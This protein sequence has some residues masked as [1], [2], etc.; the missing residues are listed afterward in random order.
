MTKIVLA[1]D[2]QV[3]RR[4]IK[5]LLSTE[6]DFDIIGEAGNG[7]ETVDLVTKLQPDILV[8]DLGMPGINGLEVT[9]QL[10][11]SSPRTGILILSMYNNQAYVV[12]ALLCGAKAYIVKEASSEELVKA[13]R[14]VIAGHRYLS[15]SLSPLIFPLNC[16]R[17]PGSIFSFKPELPSSF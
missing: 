7:L 17:L 16:S 2:H 9:R 8:L 15:T 3:V 14:E 1:D 4:G 11:K 13:I 6:S 12:E 10:D 5:T